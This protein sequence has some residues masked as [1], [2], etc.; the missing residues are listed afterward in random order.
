MAYRFDEYGPFRSLFGRQGAYLSLLHLSDRSSEAIGRLR[1]AVAASGDQLQRYLEV[2]LGEPNWRPQ[3]VA[4]MALVA[5][6]R[7]D[8]GVDA[9]WAALDR[10]CWTSPQLAAAACRK[11]PDF[12]DN[13]RLRLERRCRLDLGEA[14][15]IDWPVRHSALGP[16]SFDSHSAKLLTSLVA[17][18]SRSRVAPPWLDALNAE[19]EVSALA[20]SDADR[21][22]EI[23][24]RWLE[25]LDELLR[26]S[27]PA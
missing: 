23:A 26:D 20:A 18:C 27:R 6:D 14:A 8:I 13:A 7:P 25:G 22:G 17:L 12:L 16:Q 21:G 3:L 5:A 11:D 10:P 9:L 15:L 2:L 1:E 24:L 4:A 19:P